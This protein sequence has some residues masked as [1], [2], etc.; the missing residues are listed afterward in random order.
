MKSHECS[1]TVLSSPPPL[2]QW[3]RLWGV[4]T[5]KLRPVRIT[6]L[7]SHHRP[8]RSQIKDHRFF[9]QSDHIIRLKNQLKK[10]HFSPKPPVTKLIDKVIISAKF[11]LN[12]TSHARSVVRTNRQSVTKAQRCSDQQRPREEKNK[13]SLMTRLV[14][15]TT[16][17]IMW[18]NFTKF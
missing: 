4:T 7:P 11:A 16:F 2:I 17:V 15:S 8:I 6:P 9:V 14:W 18:G 5:W 1:T 3:K 12:T 13:L 10:I